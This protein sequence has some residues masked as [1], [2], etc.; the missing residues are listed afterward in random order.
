M[1]AAVQKGSRWDIKIGEYPPEF[2]RSDVLFIRTEAI[3]SVAGGCS[4]PLAALLRTAPLLALPFA[5]HD[6]I[7]C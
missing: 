1:E 6:T 7:G 2:T 3:E 5:P 4:L